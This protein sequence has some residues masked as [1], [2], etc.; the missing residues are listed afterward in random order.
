ISWAG[1]LLAAIGVL[2][3][4]GS[5]WFYDRFSIRGIALFYLLLGISVLLGLPVAGIG[6]LLLFIVVR[7]IAHGGLIVDVPILTKHYFGMERIGMTMGIMAVCVNLGFA[8]GPPIFGWM[9]D[10]YGSYSPGVAVFG[11]VAPI[12]TLSIWWVK[13]RYWAPPAQREVLPAGQPSV[14][15]ASR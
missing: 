5:G 12:A 10:Q 14:A 4:I 7:G 8:A 15:A 3:K 13:P 2:A 1:A 9:A 11:S 6:T